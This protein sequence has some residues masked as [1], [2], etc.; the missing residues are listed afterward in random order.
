MEPM[1]VSGSVNPRRG[2]VNSEGAELRSGS[3]VATKMLDDLF[4]KTTT[5]PSIYWL[6]LSDAKVSLRLPYRN[7]HLLILYSVY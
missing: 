7:G 4:R 6:P 1:S 2:S 3:P 5:T